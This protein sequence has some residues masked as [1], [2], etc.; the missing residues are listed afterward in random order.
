[1][2]F[3]TKVA[4]ST[5]NIN[6]T[7]CPG[8]VATLV[9]FLSSSGLLHSIHQFLSVVHWK[10]LLMDVHDGPAGAI[11]FLRKPAGPFFET[12]IEREVR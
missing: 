3:M 9:E 11:F 4:N 7:H 12:L 2:E 10:L 5:W 8:G 1:M 6:T